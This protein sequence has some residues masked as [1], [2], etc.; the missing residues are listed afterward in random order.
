[1]PGAEPFHADAWQRLLGEF[2]LHTATTP[3]IAWPGGLHTVL[4]LWAESDT[5]VVGGAA[6]AHEGSEYHVLTATRRSA[7]R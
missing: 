1:V 4:R 7:S 3:D 2:D 5:L 6:P